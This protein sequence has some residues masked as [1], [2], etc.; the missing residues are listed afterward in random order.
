MKKL[1]LMAVLCATAAILA[2]SCEDNNGEDQPKDTT[3]AELKSFVL[4]ASD[5]AELLTEDVVAS[6]ISENMVVRVPGGGAN[7]TFIATLTAGE[8]D[9]I[10][11]NDVNCVDG[12]AS[13]DAT[14]PID[15]VVT[16]TKSSLSATYEVK[17]GKVLEVVLQSLASYTDPG[18]GTGTSPKARMA[19]SP[20]DNSPYICYGSILAEG[21]QKNLSTIK[22]NG[23]SFDA[24]GEMGFVDVASE[25]AKE[26]N[27]F[28]IDFDPDGTL[29]ALYGGG[30]GGSST[31]KISVAKFDGS[32]WSTVG[33]SPI[34]E[35]N[36]NTTYGVEVFT[37]GGNPAIIA[38]GNAKPYK[39]HPVFYS[40]NG[41]AWNVSDGIAG[42]QPYPD[43]GTAFAF[44]KAAVARVS[45]AVYAV[46]S[47]N[48]DGY[49]IF[50]CVGNEWTKVV[51][52]FVPEG[53]TL[54]VPVNMKVIAGKSNSVF[55]LLPLYTALKVQ[56]YKLNES[57]GTLD[58]AAPSLGGS[59]DQ[60]VSIGVNPVSG[61]II[62]VYD[63]EDGY[64]V[65]SVLDN[66]AWDSGVKFTELKAEDDYQICYD[67]A[68]NCFVAYR[69]ESGSIEFFK[70]GLED[71]VLPE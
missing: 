71:D 59:G 44:Y 32:A 1:N 6:P 66:G 35:Q 64:P 49:Y 54:G 40:F 28:D 22:W 47:A 41:S 33:S 23:T 26:A 25:G 4:L 36:V 68:G 7:K 50:K 21:L 29:Y 34:N 13:V 31:S 11:V 2:V 45:D 16:N 5:N 43:T 39:R 3:P 14:Y 37:I 24:V 38:S 60:K 70:Y 27:I 10:M 51:D 63:G 58:V 42:Y 8:N 48:Q 30:I 52:K 46:T 69:S 56:L 15:I 20:I 17:V 67:N 65:F 53:E 62:A 57:T 18:V 9:V 19:I 61:E 55:F 12:K